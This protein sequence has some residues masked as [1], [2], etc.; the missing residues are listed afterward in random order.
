MLASAIGMAVA[1]VYLLLR[2]RLSRGI[3]TLIVTAG[4]GGI[5]AGLFAVL[6]IAVGGYVL[7]AAPVACLVAMIM[8]IM[9]MNKERELVIEDKSRDKSVENRETIMVNATKY[10][11]TPIITFGAIVAFITVIMLG[12]GPI[13]TS[14]IYMNILFGILVGGV[15]TVVLLG[16]VAQIFY[17]LFSKVNIERP[18]KKTKKTKA[19]HKSAEPE[20]AIFIGIND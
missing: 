20:E 14:F 3:A 7:L 13:A 11:C 1:A 15:M 19:V 8:E 4:I 9:L 10:S 18:S 6:P 2:Y 12:F 16:P 17:K 5:T